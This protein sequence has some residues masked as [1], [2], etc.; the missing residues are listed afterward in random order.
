[1]EILI[2]HILKEIHG[3]LA[4]LLAFLQ[5]VLS[6][7]KSL[8][9]KIV[10]NNYGLDKKNEFYRD[11]LDNLNSN[12]LYLQTANLEKKKV[13]LSIDSEQHI[14][15]I[16]YTKEAAYITNEVSKINNVEIDEISV[17][18]IIRGIQIN[19]IIYQR[20]DLDNHYKPITLI[21]R[22]SKIRNPYNEY[23]FHEFRPIA[24]FPNINNEFSPDIRT[25]V[26]SPE[27]LFLQVM[28]LKQSQKSNLIEI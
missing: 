21:K 4:F 24:V 9:Q 25:H 18:N 27:E 5:I 8:N 16:R 22:D 3:I 11:L 13:N 7:K 2:F 14:N 19:E 28:A 20:K 26:G 6:K 23:N 10:N 1:M 15:P 12:K 17:S